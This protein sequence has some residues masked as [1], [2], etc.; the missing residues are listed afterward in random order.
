V[1][2]VRF[3]AETAPDLPWEFRPLTPSVRVHLGEQREVFYRATNHSAVPVTGTA[4]FN[5]TPTK[6]GI[7]FDKLQCFCFS[8]QRLE[9]GETRDMGVSF[10]VDPDLAKDPGARDVRT[11]TLS[12]TMFRK[13]D[14]DKSVKPS[15]AAGSRGA[16]AA[17]N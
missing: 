7:Y 10:F 2:T 6:S 5:V 17:V 13:P 15:A 12:Y 4:T 1:V 11:I 8:E 16:T 3:D 9:A 14:A